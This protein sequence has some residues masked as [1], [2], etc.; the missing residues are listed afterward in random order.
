MDK[1]AEMLGEQAFRDGL[2]EYLNTFG[3]S[4]ASWD[5][6]V[7]ILNKRTDTD[8]RE[9]SDAW[10][11]EPGIPEYSGRVADGTLEICQNDPSGS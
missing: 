1:L 2:R 6:L 3:Y 9:W 5:D 8:L 10:I 4:N 11:K 7:D